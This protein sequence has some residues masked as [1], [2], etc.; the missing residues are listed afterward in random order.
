MQKRI[1]KKSLKSEES[2]KVDLQKIKLSIFAYFSLIFIFVLEYKLFLK[3][4][5]VS[6]NLC[7]TVFYLSTFMDLFFMQPWHIFIFSLLCDYVWNVPIGFFAV[8]YFFIYV[9]LTSQRDTLARRNCWMQG[10]L[11]LAMLFIRDGTFSILHYL[12]Y[13]NFFFPET[14]LSLAISVILYP[15]IYKI[16]LFISQKFQTSSNGQP[17][18]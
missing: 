18:S 4:G 2:M 17:F 3:R 6:T 8:I 10:S 15:V 13:K 16:C 11:F 7:F 9:G 5:A 1:T 14:C 12:L